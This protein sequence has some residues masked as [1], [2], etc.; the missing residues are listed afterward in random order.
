MKRVK[1]Y[2]A[3]GADGVFAPY[4]FQEND[5]REIASACNIPLNIVAMKEL[6]D[7]ATL[8]SWGVRR[9]SMGS[10]MYRSLQA[11]LKRK[12]EAARSKGSFRNI[13]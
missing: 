8:A 4:I 5:V 12:T 10:S 1:A 6:P 9:L 2:Q 7:F 11:D 3:A 13:F